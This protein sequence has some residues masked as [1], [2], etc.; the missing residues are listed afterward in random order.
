[1]ERKIFFLKYSIPDPHA[2]TSHNTSYS[3]AMNSTSTSI[4]SIPTSQPNNTQFGGNIPCGGGGGGQGGGGCGNRNNQFG[5]QDAFGSGSGGNNRNGGG[6]GPNN[7][8]SSG[9]DGEHHVDQ[10]D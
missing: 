3:I 4:H 9:Q 10:N 6:G 8:Q 5:N 2:S 1:M 7:T